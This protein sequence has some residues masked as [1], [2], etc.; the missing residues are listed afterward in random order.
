MGVGVK[1]QQAYARVVEK[2]LASQ[3]QGE[4]IETINAG[5]NATGPFH[6]FTFLKHEGLQLNPDIVVI[7][8]FP[9]N[10]ISYDVYA[11]E[12]VLTRDGE[13]FPDTVDSR[14]I[15]VDVDGS[16][17]SK[18]LPLR[19]KIPFLRDLH[20]YWVIVNALSP[21]RDQENKDFAVT[22]STCL[23]NTACTSLNESENKLKK[24]FLSLRKLSKQNDFKL[25][26]LI[27]L[28][29]F[30]VDPVTFVKYE[31]PG[32]VLRSNSSLPHDEFAAFFE[33]NQIEYLDLLPHFLN[34]ATEQ[35]YF[36]KD[37]HWNAYGHQLA[38]KAIEQ[39]LLTTFLQEQS[40]T[41][42]PSINPAPQKT[43]E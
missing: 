6:Q 2:L 9:W 32:P 43:G 23:Y 8:F 5:I 41:A 26:V 38:A 35:A 17:R 28:T 24:L 39:N 36:D 34:E 31:L 4:K 29:E 11:S 14:T 25:L 27:I 10:D 13:G 19:F 21:F 33:K 37:P 40:V 15:Y 20:S 42:S 22:S 16:M 1:E 7:G 18:K 3:L 12:K 30:Q